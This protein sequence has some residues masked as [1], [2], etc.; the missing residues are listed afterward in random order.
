M[1]KSL[2]RASGVLIGRKAIQSYLDI[3]REGLNSLIELGLPMA[4]INGRLYAHSENIE[5]WFQLVTRRKAVGTI[6][7][8]E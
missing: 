4:V 8:V 3:G 1:A 5:Q 6:D 2:S 7:E